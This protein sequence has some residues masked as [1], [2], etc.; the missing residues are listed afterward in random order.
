[1]AKSSP[2][3]KSAKA[4]KKPVA[5]K[6]KPAKV[7]A[8]SSPSS[9]KNA[10]SKK[11]SAAPKAPA[12]SSRAAKPGKA[13]KPKQ[14]GLARSIGRLVGK[15]TTPAKKAPAGKAKAAPAKVVKKAPA[16]V[17]K[18]VQAAPAKK[19]LPV[20]SPPPVVAKGKPLPE[21]KST[22]STASAVAV[23]QS[24]SARAASAPAKSPLAAALAGPLKSVKA[25]PVV[26][27]P[28]RPPSRPIPVAPPRIAEPVSAV[29]ASQWGPF[30][31]K[32]EKKRNDIL[33]QY[34]RDLRSGQEASDDNT[35]DLV[36]RANNAISR[37]L[38]F[39]LSDT[40]RQLLL[41][42][43]EALVRME[44]G[45]YGRCVHCSQPIAGPRL[46]AL[47]WAKYCI[48]CQEL[49]EKGLLEDA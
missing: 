34:A 18:P 19:P 9:A 23:N 13:A 46:D 38:M 32:L 27:K 16:R 20:K 29:P 41:Q 15:L 24:T 12:R 36:D 6:V 17:A 31:E 37:E 8:K 43:E 33:D 21:K 28:T 49:Q 44:T 14:G 39:S 45:T 35:D 5:K 40:E 22:G 3:A 4:G 47:P 2:S 26:K 10:A 11:K 48:D 25:A 1:V 7:K 42:V 30:R